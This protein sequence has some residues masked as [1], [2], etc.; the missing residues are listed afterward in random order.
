M[1]SEE[2]LN[3]IWH[4]SYWKI[5][6][7]H[8]RRNTWELSYFETYS[9][10]ISKWKLHNDLD[11]KL[12]IL[13]KYLKS[14]ANK[15]NKTLVLKHQ[16]KVSGAFIFKTLIKYRI[17]LKTFYFLL[18]KYGKKCSEKENLTPNPTPSISAKS[19]NIN[20]TNSQNLTLSTAPIKKSNINRNDNLKK[21]LKLSN[22]ASAKISLTEI[23]Q[24]TLPNLV[25]P[26]L[27]H[28]KSDSSIISVERRFP[29]KI[30]IW[31]D[32]KEKVQLW[33]SVCVDKKYKKP[34]FGSRIITC[35]KDI[36][37]ASEINIHDILTPLDR[38]ICFLDGRA[39]KYMAG[40]PDFIV[41][42]EN[43]KVLIPFEYKTKWVLKVPFNKNI[44][45]LYLQEKGIRER[46]F[47]G[48][49]ETS[50]YNP[51]NQIYG[52]MCANRLCYGVLSTFD[53]TWFLKRG[54]IGNHGWL[55]VSDVI[56]NTSTEPT[57]LKSIAYIISIA[58]NNCYSPFIEKPL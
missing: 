2:I 42:D 13:T 6:Y 20:E 26:Q 23:I 16:L 9:D 21:S 31:K 49:K 15:S 30:S 24:N 8:W 39:L 45:E 58:S 3:K 54:I 10:A 33:K 32:F 29:D 19:G 12:D 28:N 56:T 57:L 48:T 5:P 14:G 44:V 46:K 34:I 55:Q 51:I 25:Y 35:E 47:V 17:L 4:G 1:L 41:V 50:A 37:T 53:Q 36:W 52:Y 7:T 22:E 27:R 38:S 18:Q 43:Y 40:E 11:N